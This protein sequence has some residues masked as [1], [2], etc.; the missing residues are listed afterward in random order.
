MNP[1]TRSLP[2]SL[3]VLLISGVLGFWVGAIGFPTWAIPVESAQVIAGLVRYPLDNPF[4]IY[5]TRIWTIVIQLCAALLRAGVSA[6]TLPRVLSGLCATAR[7]QA[8][9]RL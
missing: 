6:I 4:Y 3:W 9:P 2:G 8:L 1:E 5:N 7:L